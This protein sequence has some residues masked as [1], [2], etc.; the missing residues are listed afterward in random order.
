MASGRTQNTAL[1]PYTRHW[2]HSQAERQCRRP[3]SFHESGISRSRRGHRGWRHDGARLRL[4]SKR[5]RWTT[6]FTATWS[7][8]WTTPGRGQIRK[9]RA[10]AEELDAPRTCVRGWRRC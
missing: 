1:H 8:G 4:G 10:L 6:A 2:L 9:G 3:V 5:N 7:T